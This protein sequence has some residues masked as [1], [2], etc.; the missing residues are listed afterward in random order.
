MIENLQFPT[1]LLIHVIICKSSFI[2]SFKYSSKS[3]PF[4]N[5]L[6]YDKIF[7]FMLN[8]KIIQDECK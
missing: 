6:Y 3:I 1:F 8:T 7:E 5:V 4:V 2:L